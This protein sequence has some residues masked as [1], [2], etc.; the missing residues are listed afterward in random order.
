MTIVAWRGGYGQT[1]LSL[2]NDD[3]WSTEQISLLSFL[4]SS[5]VLLLRFFLMFYQCLNESFKKS[6]IKKA[7]IVRY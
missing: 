2:L 1:L 3:S 6:F 7:L 5:D 4:M